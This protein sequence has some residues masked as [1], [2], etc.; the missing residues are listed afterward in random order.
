[1]ETSSSSLL[2]QQTSLACSWYAI[3]SYYILKQ[4]E[5]KKLQLTSPANEHLL[6]YS[7]TKRKEEAKAKIPCS[8]SLHPAPPHACSL[9]VNTIHCSRKERLLLYSRT[10]QKK[11]LKLEFAANERLLYYSRTKQKKKLKLEFAAN[12]RL[13]YYSRTKRK[14][15]A[16]ARILPSLAVNKHS[17]LP[18]KQAAL[19]KRKN[20]RASLFHSTNCIII[21]YVIVHLATVMLYYMCISL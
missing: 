3:D 2:L 14:E 15:E 16:K 4:S 8:T 5:R 11:K 19:F 21:Y 1:M 18:K 6:Y 10:K 9:A 13:L 7:R 20:Y 12:E 17:T